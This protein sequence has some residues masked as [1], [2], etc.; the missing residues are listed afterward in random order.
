M[1]AAAAALVEAVNPALTAEST[2][3][4]LIGTATDVGDPGFDYLYGYGLLNA[5][6]AVQTAAARTNLNP[7][8]P[9]RILDTRNGTGGPVA[10]VGQAQTRSVKVTGVGGVP[11]SGVSAVVLN[12]TITNAS[13]GSYLTLFP[14]DGSRPLAS[15]LNFGPGQNVPNLVVVKVGADGNVKV[16]NDQG[17]VD[18]IFDVAGWY[19]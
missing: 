12:V 18:V 19:T 6:R 9:A 15:N 17:S 10:P 16:Y 1:V 7:L 4:I 13:K 3:A 14:S 2:R 5:A 11:A 8:T